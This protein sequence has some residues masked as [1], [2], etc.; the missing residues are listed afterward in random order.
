[1]RL[2]ILLRRSFGSRASMRR[3]RKSRRNRSRKAMLVKQIRIHE[4]MP[5]ASPWRS[6]RFFSQPRHL[7]ESGNVNEH[8]ASKG[9]NAFLVN[10]PASLGA[11]HH[12]LVVVIAL[13]V[14]FCALTPF[15]RVPLPRIEAFIPI[16]D[17]TLALIN[18]VT[19]GLLLVVFRRSRMRA[20][21]YFVGG[22]SLPHL[23]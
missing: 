23:W 15:V 17:S 5:A 2:G 10:T 18:L 8:R 3:D 19:S 12:A 9:S 7:S 20:V 6:E 4:P 1:M 11:R 14:A 22:T 21:L 13:F 16:F